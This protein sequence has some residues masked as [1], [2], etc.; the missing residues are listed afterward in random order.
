MRRRIR[1][2]VG[3]VHR[4][5]TDGRAFNGKKRP[6]RGARHAQS[7]PCN[8]HR[9]TP[10][11]PT[12]DRPVFPILRQF[13]ACQPTAL[14]AAIE[15]LAPGMQRFDGACAGFSL[16]NAYFTSPDAEVAYAMVSLQKPRRIIEVGSGY[17]TFLLREAIR[18]A[19]LCATLTSIDPHPRRAIEAVAD[20]VL[21]MPVER[22]P[23]GIFVALE[24]DDILFIDSSHQVAAG[25]DVVVLMLDILPSLK[26]GVIVHFHDVF[27]PFDYPR[28][29]IV[30]RRWGWTEQYL[31]Q[32]LLQGSTEFEVLWPGRYFQYARAEI[33]GLF[34]SRHYGVATSLWLRRL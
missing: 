29:W 22:I 1:R 11:R 34:G 13:A 12:V 26:S 28:E 7:A 27:L 10:R 16:N 23:R 3:F 21:T 31:L 30:D 9:G 32:A 19:N 20:D 8:A 17:S 33:A 24:A 6:E 18:G 4:G 5:L 14:I 15:G 2:A 25:S